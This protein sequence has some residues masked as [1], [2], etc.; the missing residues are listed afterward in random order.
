MIKAVKAVRNKEMGYLAAAKLYNVPR[1]TLWDYV[2][3]NLDP[4]QATQS[5]VGRESIIPPALEEKLVEYLL[6]IE[7]KYFNSIYF[8]F[9]RSK[10][11][12]N[13]QDIEHV[14]I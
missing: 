2:R 9:G 10:G 8:V 5:N 12:I 4:F 13:P 3:S 11:G 1:S 14:N 6:L 7:R